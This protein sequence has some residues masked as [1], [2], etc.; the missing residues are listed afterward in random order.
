MKSI[1]A[2]VALA[3]SLPV[4]AQT[5][6]PPRAP[7]PVQLVVAEAL[8]SFIVGPITVLYA[9]S[10]GPWQSNPTLGI[11]NRYK[12][13]CEQLLG[14]TWLDHAGPSPDHCPDGNWLRVWGYVPRPK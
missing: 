2:V 11:E 3:I 1:F 12:Q 5:A 8:T 4:F 9:L 14:G 13:V 6:P 10:T 7:L